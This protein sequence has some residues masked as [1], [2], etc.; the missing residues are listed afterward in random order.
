MFINKYYLKN[1][2]KYNKYNK[3]ALNYKSLFIEQTE[4]LIDELMNILP[5]NK[6]VEI[7][8]EQYYFIKKA[9]SKMIVNSFVKY[10]LPHKRYIQEK[11][12]KFFLEGGGQEEVSKDNYNFVLDIKKD[13]YTISVNNKEIIWKYFNVLVL[14]SEKIILQSLSS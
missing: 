9:N 10:V 14:L 7:F 5:E 2:Y 1:Y 6:N 8:K 12:E 11:N 3:M 13:W 4:N